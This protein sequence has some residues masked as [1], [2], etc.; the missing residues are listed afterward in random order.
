MSVAEARTAVR[1]AARE[2]GGKSWS[3]GKKGKAAYAIVLKDVMDAA[4]ALALAVHVEAC[5]SR[6]GA[7][8]EAT[9]YMEAVACGDSNG[10]LCDVALALKELG[11]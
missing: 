2:L 3:E 1:V 10:W 4:D 8:D 6:R 11:S 9:G 7:I 5:G